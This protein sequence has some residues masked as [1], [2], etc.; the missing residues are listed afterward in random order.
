MQEDQSKIAETITSYFSALFQSPVHGSEEDLC[1]Q[2]DC[3]SPVISED[4][5]S[6]L[7]RD[8]TDEEIKAA[9]FSLG[10]LKSPGIDGFPAVFYQRHWESIK[11]HVVKEVKDFGPLVIWIERSTR[12]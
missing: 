10:P 4:M 1:S 5:N 6:M 8:I 2:L 7:L 9:V 12:H 11:N 3:I